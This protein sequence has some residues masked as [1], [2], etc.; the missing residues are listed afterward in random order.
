MSVNPFDMVLIGS[1]PEESNIRRHKTC[2]EHYHPSTVSI[3]LQ[4]LDI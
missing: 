3:P 4:T 2:P 1:L